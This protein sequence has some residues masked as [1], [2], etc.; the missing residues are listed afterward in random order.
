MLKIKIELI[1][2]AESSWKVGSGSSVPPLGLLYIAGVLNQSGHEVKVT[3]QAGENLSDEKLKNKIIKWDPEVIGVT[4]Y[5]HSGQK[6]I[7]LSQIFH[8]NN[9][10]VRIIF[11]GYFASFNAEKILETTPAVDICVRGEGEY[12]ALDLI[13][14]LQKNQTLSTI[15]GITYR[16]NGIVKSNPDR[17]FI[18]D[19]DI[20]PIPDRTLVS[21]NIYG[22]YA[23]MSIE[24]FTTIGASRGCPYNCRFCLATQWGRNRWRK[25]DFRKIVDELE[26]LTYLGYQNILFIDDNF[27]A[28]RNHIIKLSQEIKHRKLDINWFCEGRTTGGSLEMYNEMRR[29]GC[30]MIYLGIESGNQKILNYYNKR[31]TIDN[32]F[33]AVKKMRKAQLDFIIGSFILG[34]P[35]ESIQDLQNTIDF[36][37]KLDIDTPVYG[38]LNV[39]KGTGIWDEYIEQGYIDPERHW[40][41]A[42]PVCDIHPDCVPRNT[43]IEIINRGYDKAL[44]RKKW[45]IK[46][47]LR[48]L[49]SR[50]RLKMFLKN[51]NKRHELRNRFKFSDLVQ[52]DLYLEEGS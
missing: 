5:S 45:Y 33:A 28:N 41:K 49:K 17:P 23:N 43:I 50:F 12:T 19:L 21:K 3:D 1:L 6:S 48:V 13:N 9:P 22:E 10:N 14:A 34:A 42:L 32:A 4:T 26:Y 24:K 35:G 40:G 52:H 16:E 36:S 39:F 27:T 8:E 29:G 15:L 37:L 20:L 7:K 18:Q 46:L 51:W 47:F 25:R 11:G 2:P 44:N 31:A 38:I 30:K